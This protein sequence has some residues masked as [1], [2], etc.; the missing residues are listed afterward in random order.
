MESKLT[1]NRAVLLGMLFFLVCGSIWALRVPIVNGAPISFNSDE[2]SHFQVIRYMSEHWSLPPYTR[3]YYESAHPPLSDW[4]EAGYIK[5]WPASMQALALRFFSIL[6]GMGILLVVFKTARLLVS[7]W[8]AA[9]ATCVCAALPMFVMFCSSV[10]N[11]PLAVLISSYALYMMV[12]GIQQGF[13]KKQL[14]VLCLVVGVAG[15]VKYTLLGLIPVAIGVVIYDRKRKGE[16]WAVPV[17]SIAASFTLISGWWFLR[18]QIMYGDPFRSRAEIAMHMFNGSAAPTQPGYWASVVSTMT[19]SLLGIYPHSPNWP[20][21]TYDAIT[22]IFGV[23]LLVAFY[24]AVRRIWTPA[25]IVLA[26]YLGLVLLTVLAYQLN[27]FQPHGRLLYPAI[28]VIVLGLS[29][30]RHLIPTKDRVL[31]G[32]LFVGG[33]A[34]LS[35]AIV[36][37]TSFN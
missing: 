24:V 7:E 12:K 17:M 25:K 35:V 19:G 10:T 33:L 1:P 22:K 28:I 9:F 14:N 16:R 11:D 32:S 36:T 23:L 6:L 26:S 5:V 30:V 4:V 37:T 2:P 31:M 13:T 15:I 34:A 8:T 3:D 20:L 21:V 27:H 29:S 18:N